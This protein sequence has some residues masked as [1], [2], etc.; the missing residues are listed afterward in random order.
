MDIIFH[1]KSKEFHLFNDKLSYIIKILKNGQLGHLYYGKRIR[2]KSSFAYHMEWRARSLGAC[3]FSDNPAFSLQYTRQEYPSYGTTDF[4]YSAFEIMQE[5]GSIISDFKYVSHEIC[6]GKKSL[7]GLPATYV[8]SACEA[9]TLE[10]TLYDSVSATEL[11]LSWSVFDQYSAITRNARFMQKGSQMIILKNAMSV[12]VDMPDGDFE[13]VH[14]AGAWGR[15][16]HICKKPVDQGV[17]SI[18]SLRGASSAEHNPFIALKRPSANEFS[19]EA[20]G[21]SLV[22]SGNF[23]AQAELDTHGMTRVQMGIHPKTFSWQLNQGEIFQTPE[24]VMVYSCEGLN[25]MSQVYHRLYRNRLMRG[26]W[27][28][29]VRPILINN[30]ET[31][32][33][34]FTEDRL[35]R[36]AQTGKE[37]GLELFVLDDGW[38]GFRDNDQTSLG[39]WYVKNFEKLPSGTNGL[40]E[41]IE[42]MG[43]KFGLWI[44]PEMV[45]KDSDLYRAHPDWIISTPDRFASPSRNQHVLD[46]SRKEVVDYIYGLISKLLCEAKISYIKWDMN[47]YITECYSSG[48]PPERQGEVF[49]RYILGVYSLY[50]RLTSEFPDVLFESCASGGA[51]S[52]PGM[53]YYAPQTWTSDN[54]DAAERIKIQYGTSLVYPISSMGAHVSD[55]PNQQVGRMTPIETRANVACFGLFGYELNLNA[56]G[57]EEKEKIKR[58]VAFVKEH[59][60]LIMSGDFVRLK[61]PFSDNEAAWMVVS[62]DRKE[63]LVGY[64]RFLNYAN[65]GMKWL[66]LAG[67]TE[68]QPYR[69]NGS[70]VIFYGDELIHAGM[71]LRDEDLTGVGTDFASVVYHLKAAE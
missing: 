46:F 6:D 50:E 29:R 18:Y 55:V 35:L 21:F 12:S 11:V 3:V 66:R 41:K 36:I 4:H 58:Q 61:S 44:E 67:L 7:M 27:R 17:Q 13:M 60:E 71:V 22:Y 9:K 40:S 38:F 24:T 8:E 64:Y 1:E 14:L 26:A 19:G 33:A 57:E 49:H 16:R 10:I 56:L 25:G 32:E 34:N 31:T 15:E 23:L 70:D 51:R 20:Y 28:D 43:M 53:L 52:D 54:T 45:S 63:A 30:W 37:L 62:I 2:D 69:I 47:R 42:S 48:L 59:R 39:D 68:T 5:N 65:K